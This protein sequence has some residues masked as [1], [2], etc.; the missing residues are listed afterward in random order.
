MKKLTLFISLLAALTLVGC[1][2]KEK[3]NSYQLRTYKVPSGLE[4]ELYSVI[5]PL[6]HLSSEGQRLGKVRTFPG[7]RLLVAAPAEFHAGVKTLIKDLAKE[8]PPR[9]KNVSLEVWHVAA[10]SGGASSIPQN[11]KS[12]STTLNTIKE[13]GFSK[14][15]LVEKL[16]SVV[17]VG[18]KVTVKGA[19][20]EA[21]AYIRFNAQ[22]PDFSLDLRGPHNRLE[23]NFHI[24][25]GQTL[26]LG[27]A[28]LIN[29][30]HGLS[31]SEQAL[32]NRLKKFSDDGKENVSLFY[33]VRANIQD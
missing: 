17:K 7:G 33:L 20:I 6:L 24:N 26:V 23:S 27:M 2:E 5:S 25:E 1:N 21:T 4:D 12:I 10:K 30:G 31:S 18:N 29:R 32:M 3:N 22:N 28:S 9:K 19:L 8:K 11:L 13:Q 16:Q 15:E 14:F